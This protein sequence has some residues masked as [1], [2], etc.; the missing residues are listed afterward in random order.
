MSHSCALGSCIQNYKTPSL[1]YID[2]SAH[3]TN[4]GFDQG[5]FGQQ[6]DRTA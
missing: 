2:P 3:Y 5:I 4:E 6:V 1:K